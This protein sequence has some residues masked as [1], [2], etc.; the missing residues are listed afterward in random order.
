M[1]TPTKSQNPTIF[2]QW[3][4]WLV[5]NGHKLA[6]FGISALHLAYKMTIQNQFFFPNSDLDAMPT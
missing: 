1:P 3:G 4:G 2:G 5:P 6:G